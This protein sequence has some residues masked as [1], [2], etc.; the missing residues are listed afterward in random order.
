MAKTKEKYLVD[1]KGRKTAV[2]LDIASY[3]ALLERVE[4]LEDTLALD[5]AVRSTSAFRPYD[6]IRAEL[7]RDGRL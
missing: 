5:E 1:N 7:E 2:Q 3:R 6:E 4:E